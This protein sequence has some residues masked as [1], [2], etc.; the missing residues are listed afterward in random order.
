M[1]PSLYRTREIFGRVV[2][3]ICPRTC[4][5]RNC[6]GMGIRTG[7]ASWA[8]GQIGKKKIG[9]NERSATMKLPD[10]VT[11]DGDFRPGLAKIQDDYGYW[12]LNRKLLTLTPSA[13]SPSGYEYEI[14]LR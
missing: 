7:W 11:A 14:D 8:G 4:P 12:H 10:G 13:D 2:F 6:C 5:Q 3:F 9:G 1:R